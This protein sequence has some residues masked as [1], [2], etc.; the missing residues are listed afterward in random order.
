MQSLDIFCLVYS[1]WSSI[2]HFRS[3]TQIQ[4]ILGHHVL[5]YNSRIISWNICNASWSCL[6]LYVFFPEYQT[7]NIRRRYVINR[8][9]WANGYGTD[10]HL[11]I[12]YS[13]RKRRWTASCVKL[14]S[15]FS[16]LLTLL[17]SF[18]ASH[19]SKLFLLIGLLI[20]SVDECI[21]Y[22]GAETKI[23]SK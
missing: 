8:Y 11:H 3:F 20:K 19:N 18:F 2:K 13:F 12:Q 10:A 16:N 6:S 4:I 7:A 15:K 23:F 1:L 21:I 14:F 17:R 22:H 9:Y 5:P